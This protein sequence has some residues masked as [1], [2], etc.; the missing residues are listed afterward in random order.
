L[1]FS[2]FYIDYIDE[3]KNPRYLILKGYKH[4]GQMSLS[5]LNHRLPE[6]EAHPKV[7]ERTADFHHEI[8]DTL[9]PQADPVFDDAAALDTTVDMLDA[10]P[11]LGQR[12]VSVP[13]THIPHPFLKF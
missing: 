12:L 6:R 10:Q 9:L 11:T 8:A 4:R 2:L 1:L 5:R 3:G 7:M 13:P